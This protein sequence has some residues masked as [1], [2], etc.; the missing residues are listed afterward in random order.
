[1]KYRQTDEMIVEL[2]NLGFTINEALSIINK[3]GDETISIVKSNPYCLNELIDFNKLD[4]VYLNIG[5]FDDE[6]RIKACLVET[7]KRLEMT[8]GDTYFS[9]EE[10]SYQLITISL[11]IKTNTIL[12]QPMKWNVPLLKTFP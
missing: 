5:A 2:K 6:T 3:Y 4:K 9:L 8:D 10:M 1:M 12:K 7:I 11:L